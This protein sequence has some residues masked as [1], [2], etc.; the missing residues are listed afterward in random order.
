MNSSTLNSELAASP[1]LPISESVE[2]ANE[3]NRRFADEL[4]KA[5]VEGL[6]R[7][8]REAAAAK[9]PPQAA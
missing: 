8:A 1:N 4:V 9:K 3:D 2:K 6:N 5:A 7:L